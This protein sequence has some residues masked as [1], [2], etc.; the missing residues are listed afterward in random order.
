ML[1]SSFGTCVINGVT[2]AKYFVCL[3]FYAIDKV[4]L[5]YHDGDMM[6]EMRRKPKP[7]LLPSQGFFNLPNH[8]GMVQ[9]ELAFDG[10]V[11]YTQWGNG[12]QPS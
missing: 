6:Y 11:S 9:E 12:L 7:I 2:D 4:F 3:L 1:T 8:L 10:T 5:L